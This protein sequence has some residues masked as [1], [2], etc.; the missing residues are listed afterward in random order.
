MVRVILIQTIR[1]IRGLFI[2]IYA[3]TTRFSA[4]S[5]D[6]FKKF[7]RTMHPPAPPLPTLK[8]FACK[9]PI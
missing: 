7:P 9:A 8:T 1:E 2:V 3:H 6:Y 5:S 4:S